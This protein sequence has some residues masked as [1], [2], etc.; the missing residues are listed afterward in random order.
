MQGKQKVTQ[1]IAARTTP[2]PRV[3]AAV[4]NPFGAFGKGATNPFGGSDPFAFNDPFAPVATPAIDEV[5]VDAPEGSYTYTLVKSTPEV[6]AEEVEDARASSVEVMILWDTTVLHVQHLTPPRSFFVGEAS[7]KGGKGEGCDYFLPEEKLGAARAPIVLADGG[8]AV[9]VVI[10]RG[11]AG[12]VEIAG[13]PKMTVKEAIEQGRTVPC[14]ELAGACQLPLPAGSTAKVDLGGLVFQITTGNAGRA[15]A[16]H[17]QVDSQGLLYAGISMAVHGGLLAAMAFFMPPLGSTGEDEISQDQTYLL[18]QYL[19]AAAEKEQPEKE[20]ENTADNQA[21]DSEG[22]TGSRALGQEGS[23][24]DSTSHKTGGQYAIKGAADNQDVHLART[25]A[26]DEAANWGI[27]G[28]LNS[29]AGGD[30]NAPTAVW[31][32]E[33]SAGN[34]ALSYNGNM[35]GNQLGESFGAGGL[36]LSGIGEGGGG[37]YE[38]IGLGKVGTF[39]SGSGTGTGNGFGPGGGSSHGHLSGTHQSK[40]PSVRVGVASVS[41]RLPPEVIQR[42]VRQNFGRF[43]LCYENGL[44][45]NPNLGGRVAVRFVIGRDGAVSNVGNGGSDLPDNGVVS[46]V[47]RAFYGLSFPQPENGIVTVTYPIVLTPGG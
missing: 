39:G 34:S 21:K 26:L 41:G 30:V 44:R 24:G 7:G 45:G 27:I 14:A 22:G 42:I 17:F 28:L 4:A 18:R 9:S 11:A 36:G 32:R 31:G 20:A 12:T 37:Q 38:G 29:G 46:C 19:D 40:P 8:G 1:D 25:R 5:P 10:P 43:R 6:P 16:G 35:W 33:D 23:M 13:Q 2:E 15:V 3:V 47:V